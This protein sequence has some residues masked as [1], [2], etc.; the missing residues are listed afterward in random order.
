MIFLTNWKKLHFPQA[1]LMLETEIYDGDLPCIQSN[2]IDNARCSIFSWGSAKNFENTL[3]VENVQVFSKGECYTQHLING[4][5][6][7]KYVNRGNNN[8]CVGS[9]NRYELDI[10]LSGSSLTCHQLNPS[11]PS[12]LKGLLTW[13]T[14]I[15][16]FPHLFTDITQFA[17]WIE[18]T[19]NEKSLNSI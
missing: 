3:K 13:S 15:N 1:L 8:I 4:K 12:I 18:Q 10:N 6:H 19:V 7:E 17:D 14:K 5:K 9:S 2:N 16:F 11:Q